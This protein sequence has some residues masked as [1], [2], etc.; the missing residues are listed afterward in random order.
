MHKRLALQGDIMEISLEW[1]RSIKLKEGYDQKLIYTL[2]FE[3]IPSSAGIY[4]FGR[5]YGK[6]FEA[7]YVGQATN[8][9]KR[10]KQ[11]IERNIKLMRHIED[12]LA[13]Y[14]ILLLAEIVPK[15]GQKLDRILPIAERVFI[16]HFLS[17]GHDLVNTK[18]TKIRQHTIVSSR[19]EFKKFIPL[20]LYAERSRRK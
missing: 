9:R 2:N 20:N 15:R 3:K 5:K 6:S 12:A 19:K 11:Q 14:R 18:G 4:V 8:M 16:K 17:E 7:L 13:S 1:K 10:I